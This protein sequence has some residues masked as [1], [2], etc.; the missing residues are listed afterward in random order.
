LDQ[1]FLIRGSLEFCAWKVQGE[2]NEWKAMIEQLNNS[3]TQQFNNSCLAPAL[4]NAL[5][6]RLFQLDE[7]RDR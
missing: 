3:T 6:G 7:K 2:K 5:A 4:L 1:P